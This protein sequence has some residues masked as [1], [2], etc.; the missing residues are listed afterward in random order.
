MAHTGNV[1]QGNLIGT[2]VT[3]KLNLGNTGDGVHITDPRAAI[4]SADRPPTRPNVIAFNGGDGVNVD[5]NSV[6]DLISQNSIF[7]NANL[8]IDL[9]NANG[10]AGGNNQ[11]PAPVLTSYTTLASGSIQTGWT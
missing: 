2:D 10:E 3:G 11:E 4:R 6:M 9:E 1:V 8:G 5:D 7:G